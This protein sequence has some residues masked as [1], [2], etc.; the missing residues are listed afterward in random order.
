MRSTLLA[1]IITTGL[2]HTSYAAEIILTPDIQTW[3]GY[4]SNRYREP[5]NSTADGYFEI[6][7]G[8]QF[9]WFASEH[10]E[11]DAHVNYSPRF[12]LDATN[13]QTRTASG[14]AGLSWSQGPWLAD[15]YAGGGWYEDSEL[16]GDDLRWL[17]AAPR[18]SFTLP[19]GC[20]LYIRGYAS[21]NEY[22]SRLTVDGQSESGQYY[23][24]RPGV[25]WP[26]TLDMNIRGELYA[27]DFNAN[28]PLDEYTGYGGTL[29]LDYNLTSLIR[30]EATTWIGQR[31]YSQSGTDSFDSRTD[32][33]WGLEVMTHYRLADWITLHA[34]GALDNADSTL[35]DSA[36]DAWVFKIG[37]SLA[38]DISLYRD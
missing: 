23:A 32:T 26:I 38:Q 31:A 37:V 21:R 9:A 18:L 17:H 16:P 5:D 2:I 4:D 35:A 20:E 27:E 13:G 34:G 22:D 8:L 36:Y 12:Y 15:L 10:I 33:P 3:M 14:E 25:Q 28:E 30:V 1:G 6:N 19:Q 11:I 29:G 24:L 7:P